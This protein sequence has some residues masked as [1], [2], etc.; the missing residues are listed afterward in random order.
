MEAQH[1]SWLECMLGLE[2][3]VVY[4]ITLLLGNVLSFFHLSN[5]TGCRALEEA[6]GSQW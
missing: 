5:I 1:V 3:Q 6:L 2:H 4:S